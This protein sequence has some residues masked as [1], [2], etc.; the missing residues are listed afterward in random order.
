MFASMKVAIQTAKTTEEEKKK[1][2]E[3]KK[4]LDKTHSPSSHAS[5]NESQLSKTTS[6]EEKESNK[7]Q[8]DSGATKCP[9]K[10]EKSSSDNKLESFDLLKKSQTM[11]P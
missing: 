8:L 2:E 9:C 10:H 11:N 1:K 6:E 3:E 4:E 7:D 5:F